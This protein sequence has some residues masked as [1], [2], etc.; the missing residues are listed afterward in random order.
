MKF[1]QDI[2]MDSQ[3]KS[4]SLDAPDYKKQRAN[5][6]QYSG[7]HG[8]DKVMNENHLDALL[9]ANNFGAELPAKAGYPSITVPA[10]Y[11]STGVPVG[12]TFSGRAYSEQRLIELAYSYE[13]HSKKRV[14]PM[15]K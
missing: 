6:V 5:D 14:P 15:F 13:L 11:T 3:N 9:F 4:E 12:V 7:K 1:G 8:I 2:L 10:G